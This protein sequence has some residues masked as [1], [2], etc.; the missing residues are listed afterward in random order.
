[1]PQPDSAPACLPFQR[2]F[3]MHAPSAVVVGAIAAWLS[4]QALAAQPPQREPPFLACNNSGMRFT[5][6]RRS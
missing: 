5:L 6:R 4:A 2:S 3:K 1:M